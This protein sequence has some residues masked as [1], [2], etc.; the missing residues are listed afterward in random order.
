MGET[1]RQSSKSFEELVL[2][3]MKGPTDKPA[4]KRRRVDLKTKIVTD[5]EYLA[6]LQEKRKQKQERRQKEN[7]EKR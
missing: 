2:N 7:P 1:S 5:A 6:E 4:V 3:K